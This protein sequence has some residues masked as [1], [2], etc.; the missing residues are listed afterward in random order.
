MAGIEKV[1]EFSDEYIGPE[2]YEHKRNHIQIHPRY[3]KLFRGA[4]H[5]LYIESVKPYFALKGGGITE[6]NPDA[7]NHYEP[8]FGSVREYVEYVRYFYGWR[9]VKEVAF[10]LK[11]DDPELAGQVEG[12]YREWTTDF[13]SLKRRLKRMLRCKRLNIVDLT[14][15]K[16]KDLMQDAV[17]GVLACEDRKE[18]K[19]AAE[20]TGK[21][22]LELIKISADTGVN[23]QRI[24][25]SIR[26]ADFRWA[27]FSNSLRDHSV[28]LPTHYFRKLVIESL[29][30]HARDLGWV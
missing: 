11:I 9:P 26:D 19:A 30:D 25:D 21:E 6:M 8:P 2:M 13:A 7:L 23:Q 29:P 20:K 28:F 18:Q 3:R 27:I 22:I 4:S 12:N 17:D 5:T 1:C 15:P 24:V 16:H 14:D 10:N